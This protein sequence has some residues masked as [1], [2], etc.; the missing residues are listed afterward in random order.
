[1]TC[2]FSFSIYPVLYCLS[3]FCFLWCALVNKGE[4]PLFPPSFPKGPKNKGCAFVLGGVCAWQQLTFLL[5]L[6]PFLQN[7]K[8]TLYTQGEGQAAWPDR[9]RYISIL[10][11]HYYTFICLALF[12]LLFLGV[13]TCP[14]SYA[15]PR[16]SGP[17]C[18]LE[19]LSVP[20]KIGTILVKYYNVLIN[21]S[22]V[23]FS[24]N[25]V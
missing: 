10:F 9:K 18:V 15:R 11:H 19:D 24:F 2:K 14:L 20:N 25:T 16:V 7:T 21:N 3:M 4:H 22:Q 12:C 13:H 8:E 23:S 17:P 5:L 6:W 1:M